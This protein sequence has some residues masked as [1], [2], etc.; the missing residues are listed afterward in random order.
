[1][2]PPF[3]APQPPAPGTAR[4]RAGWLGAAAVALSLLGFAL[5]VCLATGFSLLDRLPNTLDQYLPTRPGQT[6]LYRIQYANGSQGFAT[7]NVV[8]PSADSIA[9]ARVYASGQAIQLHTTY[10]NWQGTGAEHALDD[11]FAR[12][13]QQLV[14]IAEREAGATTLFQPA[15][16]VWTPRLAAATAS[17]PITGQTT[18]N[19][20]TLTYRYWRAPN[21]PVSLPDGTS[22]SALRAESEFLNGATLINHSSSWYVA[23]VG[24]VR[25]VLT[26]AQGRTLQRLDLLAST[27]L[28]RSA[29]ARL[30]LVDL[31]AGATATTA[32]FRE[33]AARTGAHPDVA[34]DPA[35]L[36]V[37]YR[38]QTGVTFIA[39]PAF[40]NSLFYAADQNGQ[41]LALDAYQAEPRWRFSAGG[42]IVAAPAVAN[43]IV[44]VPAGDKTLYAL[45]AQRGMYLWSAPFPDNLAASPVVADGVL[46]IGAEDRTLYAIDALTGQARWRFSAGDRLVGSPAL[47]GGRVIFGSDDALVY[48]LDAASGRLLW[49]ATLDGPVEATPVVDPSGVVYAASNGSQLTALDGATGAQLWSATTRFGYL[50]SPALGD[51]LIFD[52]DNG[53]TF[54]AFDTHTGAIVWEARAPEPQPFVSSPLVLGRQVLAADTGG[55]LF[56]WDAA[57]GRLQQQIA[58]GSAVTGSPA[59]TGDAVL[60]TNSQGELLALQSSPAVRGLALSPLWQHAFSDV[61]SSNIFAGSLYAQ[62]LLAGD[63]LVAV[64]QGGSLWSLEAATGAAAHLADLGDNVLG[65]LAQVGGV[66]YAGTQHGQVAAYRLPLGQP[67]WSTVLG[68]VIRFGPAA[69]AQQVFVNTLTLT[70]STITA[71][72]AATG[73]VQ[74]RQS[75]TNG[76]A[77][78][79]LD[80]GRLIVAADS[81]LALDPNSGAILWQ[82]DAFTVSGSLAVYNGLVYAGGSGGQGV[83][84]EALDASTGQSVW[85]ARDPVRFLYSRPAYD[86]AAGLILAGASAGQLLAYDARTGQR[87]WSFTAD[88][89][90]ES[91]PQVQDGVVYVTSQNGTLYAVEISSG[92]LLTSFLPGTAI[93]TSAAPLAAP[94]LVFTAHGST[95][96]AFAARAP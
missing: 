58:L 92:R 89:P 39:S 23:N 56:V 7:A 14:Q 2:G 59:W 57:S 34:L 19:S 49:R 21:E 9:Y 88:S 82:S 75:F 11:F 18:F 73:A 81:I 50:A 94:G 27:R 43:G 29:T 17:T 20:L 52:G 54:H 78:P 47:Y 76:A 15:I 45:D 55:R 25:Y 84:F 3:G 53:G 36:H 46:Y 42:P 41:L 79:L 4:P 91:D 13:G 38:L 62:P 60:L 5:F 32:F 40:A 65:N 66:V 80:S 8:R 28:P 93:T 12:D 95:L 74:W 37:T 44:Y 86:P 16:S 77:Q 1:M 69:S 26:D 96:Y 10:T 51:G 22:R 24:L 90:L 67:L 70:S 72:D 61:S 87:H 33:D 48:A 68:G 63:R 71:L 64:L 83:S 31:L 85:Q 35:G 30:P 6:S